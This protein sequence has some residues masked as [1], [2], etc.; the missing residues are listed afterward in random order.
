MDR[1]RLEELLQACGHLL[2]A[3]NQASRVVIVGGAALLLRGVI[4]RGTRDV[5]AIAIDVEGILREAAELPAGLHKVVLDV[6]DLFEADR[7]WLNVKA[8]GLL[9]WGLLDGRRFALKPRQA[10][11]WLRSL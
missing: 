4:D 6:A 5:D 7:D 10:L 3:R 8:S 11:A 1:R 9:R 2:G